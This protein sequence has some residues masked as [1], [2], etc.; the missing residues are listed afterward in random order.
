MWKY[1]LIVVALLCAVGAFLFALTM[2]LRDDLG[3]E[4]TPA[5]NEQPHDAIPDTNTTQSPGAV[6]GRGTALPVLAR[7]GGTFQVHDIR[8]DIGT[9]RVDTDS[10]GSYYILPAAENSHPR[11]AQGYTLLFFERSTKFT[12][13]LTDEPF[14]EYQRKAEQDLQEKLGATRDDFCRL[15]ISVVAAAGEESIPVTEVLYMCAP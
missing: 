13:M 14:A 2:V 9:L 5:N 3:T 8:N 4:N 10:E 1:G 6:V 15:P 12:I 7:D 11:A